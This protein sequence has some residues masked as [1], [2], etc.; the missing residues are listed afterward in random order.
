M[1][2]REAAAAL[3]AGGI[4]AYPTEA[5]YGLGCDPSDHDAVERLCA[6]K[7]RPVGAGLILIAADPAQLDGWV[8]PRDTEFA[9][10]SRKTGRV[11]T[12][13]VTAADTCPYW[14]TG[15][16]DGVAVRITRHPVA[17]ALCTAAGI[18]LVS[19]SANR[20]ARPPARTALEVRRRFGSKIALVLAGRTGP[21]RQPSEIRDART[22]RTLRAGGR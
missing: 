8:A 21:Q 12:W 11:V 10:L 6:L 20:R 16:R 5:V 14:I 18:P 1:R 17:A 3:R 7:Q 22:G 4:V 9:R 19:T 2:V 13:V 15:G